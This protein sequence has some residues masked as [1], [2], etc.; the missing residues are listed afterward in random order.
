MQRNVT[1]L[2][3]GLLVLL[4]LAACPSRTSAATAMIF[5]NGN[6]GSASGLT[7]S[8]ISGFQASDFTTMVLFAMS[9]STNSSFTYGGQTICSNGVYV[10]PSNWGSLL[11]QCLTAPSSVTRIEMCLGGAGDTSWAN[12]KNLIA[13]NGT[14]SST[15]L[16]KNLSA[17]K[18]ALG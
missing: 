13:A 17:L 16:Y 10:G 12:I 15:V 2:A 11:S 7:S 9:V 6:M 14:H 18:N 1:C 5:C 4:Q 3:G 8:Q